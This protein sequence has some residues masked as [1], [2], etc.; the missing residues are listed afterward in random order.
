[1]AQFK[2]HNQ[3][4]VNGKKRKGP[5]VNIGRRS[6]KNATAARRANDKINAEFNRRKDTLVKGKKWQAK[7]ARVTKLKTIKKGY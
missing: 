2:T 5:Y 4:Y 1:M 7:T 3:M 6:F